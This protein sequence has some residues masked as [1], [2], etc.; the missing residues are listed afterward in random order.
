MEKQI[1]PIVHNRFDFVITDVET[2][3][4]SKAY[5]ELK[6]Q[7]EN[8]VLDRMYTRLTN[9]ST[10]FTNIVY[11]SGT[12][13]LSA[14]RTTL[15]S[16]VN[17][18]AATDVTLVRSYPLSVWTRK[19]RLD[20]NDNNG[21]FLR[22][23]GISDDTTLINTHALITDSEGNPIEIE[24]TI[25]KIIDI[26]ATVY[27]ELY[28]V[29]SGLNFISNGLRDYLTGGSAPGN[30]M[31]VSLTKTDEFTAIG[32][33]KTG[34]RTIDAAAKS[35][36]ISAEWGVSDW[37]KDIRY[38]AWTSVGVRCRIPR[39]GVFTGLQKNNVNVGTAN[40]VKTTFNIPNQD[41]SN[42]VMKVDGVQNNNWTKN[43]AEQIVFNPAPTTGAVTMSYMTSLFPKDINCTFKPSI[44]IQFA[45]AQPSPV[46]PAT[47]YTAMPG[48]ETPIAGDTNYGYFGEVAADDFINGA[49]LCTLLGVTTGTLINSL[50]GWSKVAKDGQRYLLSKMCI[51]HTISWNT[52]NALGCVYG[53]KLVAVQGGLY[54][55]RMLSDTE[56]N[57]LMYPLHTN[58]DTWASFT[59]AELGI[60]NMYTLTS[61]IDG[62]ARTVRG[63]DS[64]TRSNTCDPST[65]TSGYGFRPILEFIRPL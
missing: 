18:K 20:V 51:R 47:D 32:Q 65:A 59:D 23:V 6:P 30:I 40:G 10:F 48:S 5:A 45:G 43:A 36:K 53:E 61:K 14:A 3:E 33:T 46:E 1:R 34:T 21:M 54:A 50:A 49:D 35:T 29:D 56:W 8:I 63:I 28:D 44:T 41:V 16:R 52:L 17:Y 9:F 22:E 55:V 15:F 26:Y 2:G 42:I 7:A 11:G 13:A 24:K 4:I 31:G 38:F 12:G 27:V 64:V 25:T 37:N 19:I 39:T 60:T 62:S 57:A 58:Y